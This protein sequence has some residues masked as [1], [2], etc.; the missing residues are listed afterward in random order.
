ME[1]G[2][3]SASTGST[4][5]SATAA[6]ATAAAAVY[7]QR[8]AG[9]SSITVLVVEDAAR[10]GPAV[11]GGQLPPDHAAAATLSGAGTAAETPSAAKAL[12]AAGAKGDFGGVLAAV[13]A[14]DTNVPPPDGGFGWAVIFASFI[15]NVFTIGLQAS[16]GVFQEAY[17][18]LPEFAGTSN[19]EISFIGSLGAAGTPLLAILF[20]RLSDKYDARAVT[21]FGAVLMGVS[22]FASS[23]SSATWHLLVTQGF[24]FG[25]STSA[26]YIPYLGV[27]PDWFSK[28]RGLAMGIASAGGGIGGLVLSPLIRFLITEVGWRW[29]LRIVGIGSLVLLL[30]SAALLRM[31]VHTPSTAKIDFSYFKDTSFLRL[32]AYSLICSLAWFVPPFYTPTYAVQYG[33]T[34]EQGALLEGLLNAAS[35]VGRVGLGFMADYTGAVNT[36]TACLFFAASAVFILWPLASSFGSMLAFVLMLGLFL[37]GAASLVPTVVAQ[38]FGSKGNLA[39]VT[40]MIFTGD[41]MCLVG[42]PIAGAIIDRHTTFLSDGS[43]SINFIPV[44]MYT[45]ACFLVC[46]LLALS[47]RI[48][49]TKRLLAKI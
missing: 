40:G 2:T 25:I 23:F 14:D 29:A 34:K 4:V 16:F 36:L 42:T 39:T 31:R 35:G 21:A 46:A 45:G 1:V 20:G 15:V 10:S 26:A 37:G 9:A 28:R 6:P 22:L 24:L 47:I 5:G 12:E 11:A 19:V 17:G 30:V 49:A 8:G 3:A 44:I 41:I 48:S 38:Q 13:E 18:T 33:M 43:K 27:L 32:F 7:Q